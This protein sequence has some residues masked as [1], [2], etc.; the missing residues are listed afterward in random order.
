MPLPPAYCNCGKWC[1]GPWPTFQVNLLHARASCI[2]SPIA[3]SRMQWVWPQWSH[4]IERSHSVAH[5]TV[6]ALCVSTWLAI[7]WTFSVGMRYV[8]S[9][10]FMLNI[11]TVASW[12]LQ[13]LHCGSLHCCARYD[14]DQTRV[15]VNHDVFGAALRVETRTLHRKSLDNTGMLNHFF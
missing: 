4:D 14:F 1:E 12:S 8:S 15:T 7:L 11:E 9:S 6:C 3:L 5:G 10:V 2:M 13:Q